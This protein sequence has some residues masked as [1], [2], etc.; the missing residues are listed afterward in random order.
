MRKKSKGSFTKELLG[1]II[2]ISIFVVGINYL[3][4]LTQYIN[5]LDMQRGYKMEMM[6][7]GYLSYDS[8]QKLKTEL[9]NIGC[10]NISIVATD[11]KVKWGQD[12]K[13]I[14]EYD[15]KIKEAKVE[16][17]NGFSIKITD[18]VKRIRVDDKKTIS[19]AT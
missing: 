13:L 9:T 17:N 19:A 5:V 14:I 3:P 16:D 15:T 1:S 10:E 8:R 18:K 11:S 6:K 2:F 4:P 12:I 7:E